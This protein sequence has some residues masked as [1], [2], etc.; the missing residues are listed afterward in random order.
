VA[1]T[2]MAADVGRGVESAKVD[3]GDEAEVR[4]ARDDDSATEFREERWIML[5]NFGSGAEG[6]G[7]ASLAF[8]GIHSHDDT[9]RRW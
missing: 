4:F 9:R 1:E 5:S 8:S 2:V 7:E 6:K 3:I